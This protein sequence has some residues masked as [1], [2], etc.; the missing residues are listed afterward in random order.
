MEG[1]VSHDVGRRDRQLPAVV[2]DD[3]SLFSWNLTSTSRGSELGRAQESLGLVVR[4]AHFRITLFWPGLSLPASCTVLGWSY[5][6]HWNRCA[7]SLASHPA[8]L[9]PFN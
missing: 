1:S 3:A 2:L 7:R 5:V 6:A 9:W 4:E 8:W